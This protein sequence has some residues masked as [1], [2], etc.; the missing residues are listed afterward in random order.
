M[1]FSNRFIL[2]AL[3]LLLLA[4]AV[5]AT[6]G[7]PKPERRQIRQ[8][9][10]GT[11]LYLK[12]DAPCVTGRHPFGV[13]YSPLVEVSPTGVN[14]EDR[15][16]VAVGYY[17]VDS[18]YWGI[19]V[20]DPVRLD[21]LEFDGDTFEAEFNGVQ[22]AEDEV[23]VIKFTGINSYADFE[24]AFDHVF[25]TQPL[26][27]LHDDWSDEVKTAIA[28]RRL[29]EGM[30]KRQVYYITGAPESFERRD[31]DGVDVEVWKL[32]T[33][34]GMRMGFFGVDNAGAVAG[35]PDELRFEGGELVN[36]VGKGTG[37]GFS[38]DD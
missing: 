36:V 20:N 24:R 13:Y 17:H 38:L 5:P 28:D 26:Q 7:V 34:K 11:T 9:M 16:G 19:R 6:A 27:Y 31:E 12:V 29:L 4:S 3:C 1:K 18:A 32:R 15:D 33:G 22:Q 10:A 23:T 21:D 30:T 35:L 2:S 25:A 14:T 37:S 8:R